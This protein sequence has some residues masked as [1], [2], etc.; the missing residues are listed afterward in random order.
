MLRIGCLGYNDNNSL[1][2][3]GELLNVIMSDARDIMIKRLPRWQPFYVEPHRM[4]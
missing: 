4:Q 1:A 2:C 3:K